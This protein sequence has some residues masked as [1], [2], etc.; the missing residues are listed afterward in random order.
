MAEKDLLKNVP[1]GYQDAPVDT[2]IFDQRNTHRYSRR[3]GVNLLSQQNP[4]I[5]TWFGLV[6]RFDVGNSALDLLNNLPKFLLFI[7]IQPHQ[8]RARRSRP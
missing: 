4:K 5:S 1:P 2:R 6:C 7:L 8:G 3:S